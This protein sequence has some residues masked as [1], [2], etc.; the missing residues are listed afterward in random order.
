MA[1]A[2]GF[3]RS[4]SGDDAASP[5]PLLAA[6]AA[7]GI[8]KRW[9]ALTD[10][11]PDLNFM[12]RLAGNLVAAPAETSDVLVHESSGLVSFATLFGAEEVNHS[13][14]FIKP[15]P[16]TID[17]VAAGCW[18]RDWATGPGSRRIVLAALPAAAARCARDS[19]LR[20]GR[21]LNWTEG[22]DTFDA[23]VER[24]RALE[25]GGTAGAWLPAGLA[26]GMLEPS[27]AAV[28]NM[29]WKYGDRVPGGAVEQKLAASIA[30]LPTACL[31]LV[32]AAA[33]GASAEQVEEAAAN[34]QLV[35][36][37][38]LRT[39]GS[40]GVMHTL[41]TWRGKGLGA[42]AVRLLMVAAAAWRRQLGAGGTNDE[43]LAAARSRFGGAVDA[44]ADDSSKC[45]DEDE[46]DCE[47]RVDEIVA[48]ATTA[49]AA[50]GAAEAAAHHMR[51][52]R[53]TARATRPYCH[54]NPTNAASVRV[55]EKLGFTPV[56][57]VVWAIFGRVAPRIAFRPL[58]LQ[59]RDEG[60]GRA[61]AAPASASVDEA[62]ASSGSGEAGTAAA[63]SD[64]HNEHHAGGDDV[65]ALQ[66]LV[67][68]SYAQDDAFFVDMVR[69]DAANLRAMG[70][71][72]VFY[73]GFAAQ[74]P[75]FLLPPTVTP[76]SK[77]SAT[78]TAADATGATSSGGAGATCAEPSGG[79]AAVEGDDGAD[80]DAAARA[81]A[82][83]FDGSG[84]LPAPMP[85]ALSS[86][87]EAAAAAAAGV[88]V[89]AS[90]ATGSAAAAAAAAAAAEPVHACP[91]DANDGKLTIEPGAEL[92]CAFYITPPR[93][94]AM[95]GADVDSSVADAASGSGAASVSASGPSGHAPDAN[96]PPLSSA[97]AVAGIDAGGSGSS[98]SS[99]SGSGAA[100]LRSCH[101]GMLVTQPHLKKSG[102]GQRLL[103]T[104]ILTAQQ[105]YGAE[106]IDCHVVAVKPWLRA[107]YE[108][109]GFA[110]VGR[111]EW[112]PAL[113]GQL[114]LP[115]EQVYFHRMVRKL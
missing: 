75:S 71:E 18:R 95:P 30:T 35:S 57:S 88:D 7:D 38:C 9:S 81:A 112:P 3:A 49:A 21:T 46:A 22:F 39:D 96:G 55:F 44:A 12:P 83:A 6:N 28:I 85:R 1:A 91:P 104:A 61:A 73:L 31:R 63:D 115:A 64:S 54:I 25:R 11:H 33:A 20:V 80:D 110:V 56:N 92:L 86:C 48:A 72:G 53:L 101:I 47:P 34:A 5:G 36:W 111:D 2:P 17:V 24:R 97:A 87:Y 45:E 67:N 23:P 59:L 107:F 26:A 78:V 99:G 79:S 108:R 40:L 13:W 69:T 113:V 10:M 42:V 68:V 103:D 19:F 94:F 77:A 66:A 58:Q 51:L 52:R 27:D 16:E 15:L 114:K 8:L 41:P 100:V 76:K 14:A 93:P 98:G 105:T 89:A 62:A 43:A 102:L 60:P 4:T 74:H 82:S 106:A 65:A 70:R 37:V 32:D 109:N 50:C 90:S 29:H 84:Y